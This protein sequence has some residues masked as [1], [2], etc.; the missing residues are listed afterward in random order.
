MFN[1]MAT[2]SLLALGLAGSTLVLPVLAAPSANY[3]DR[4]SGTWSGSGKVQRDIDPSP[5]SVDCSV[6][7]KRPSA[8]RI[9]IDGTCRALVVFSR[10]MGAEISYNPS[11]GRYSG[12]YTG[13]KTG[14]AR[15]SGRLQ[16]NA[17]VFNVDYGARVYD[18]TKAVM[19]ITNSGNGAFRMVV[20]DKFKGKTIQTSNVSFSKR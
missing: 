4:F 14:P 6:S 3:L 12:V 9:S 2:T 19:T 5:R 1:R 7:S 16:G 8:N 18:D 13:S 15:L 20:T 17:L 11:T 10:K